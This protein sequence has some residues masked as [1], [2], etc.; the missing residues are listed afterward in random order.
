[1]RQHRLN[2]LLLVVLV[3]FLLAI[4][5]WYFWYTFLY[6][7]SGSPTNTNNTE[8]TVNEVENVTNT[9]SNSTT[10][11][12]T[13]TPTNNTVSNNTT[14]E[15]RNETSTSGNI[16]VSL[17]KANA[18]L[19]KT[20]TVSGYA[21]VF[22]GVVKVRVKDDKGNIL[23]STYVTTNAPDTGRTGTFQKSLS[24]EKTSTSKKGTIEFFTT[25][26]AKGGERDVVSI[27][28]NF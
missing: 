13:N 24:L 21:K 25:D 7:R 3:L 27:A 6:V 17:P 12:T 22:E 10:N 26:E 5:G 9:T 8:T 2:I 11:T 16:T 23:L 15:T 4:V 28:V 1:M 19:G 20:F 18:T 14:T